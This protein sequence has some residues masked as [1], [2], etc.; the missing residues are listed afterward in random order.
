[1]TLHEI[2]PKLHLIMTLYDVIP[3]VVGLYTTVL[4]AFVINKL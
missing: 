1:M 2:L 3:I 4:L